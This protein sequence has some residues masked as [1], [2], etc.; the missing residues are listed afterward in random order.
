MVAQVG[1]AG[2]L[3]KMISPASGKPD[4]LE[5][6]GPL[7]R[8]AIAP[9]HAHAVSLHDAS[10]KLVWLSEGAMGP[11]AHNAAINAAECFQLAQCAPIL[12]HDLGDRRSAVLIRSVDAH[13]SFVGIVMFVVDSQAVDSERQGL[14]ELITPALQ[15]A[16]LKFS[17]WRG[18]IIEAQTAISAAP[19]IVQASANS[20]IDKFMVAL[21]RHPLGLYIQRLIPLTMGGASRRYEVLLRSPSAGAPN[22]A[23]SVMLKAAIENGL[24]HVIDRRVVAQL[25]EW[26][27]SH[28]NAW[29]DE[30]ALFTVNLT[31]TTTEDGQFIKFLESTLSSA[32]LKPAIV[33]FELDTAT[34]SRIGQPLLEVARSLERIG[35][36][37]ILDNFS[38]TTECIEL[39]HLPGVKLLKIAPALTQQMRTDMHSQ[40]TISSICQMAK[41]LGIE[42]GAKQSQGPQ[43][44]EWLSA[45]GLDFVQSNDLSPPAPLDSL[46]TSAK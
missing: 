40:A 12:V 13:E 26:L 23:P 19:S 15:E 30:N 1:A 41:L 37:L 11:E 3:G 24:G 31:A 5:A 45:L 46:T 32:S 9:A 2:V 17:G 7:F 20:P 18:A 28:H 43:D 33:G 38:L 22:V 16:L 6:V 42:T 14:V 44:Q 21:H 8:T 35:C 4:D 29:A 39:L 25:C 10:G 36:P 34:I 27:G